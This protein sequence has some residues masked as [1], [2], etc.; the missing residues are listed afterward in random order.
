MTAIVKTRSAAHRAATVAM[1][2]LAV[3]LLAGPRRAAADCVNEA[4]AYGIEAHAPQ[5]ADLTRLLDEVR[6]CGIGWIRIDVVWS[7]VEPSQNTFNWSIYDAIASAAQARGIAVYASISNTPAWATAGPA[8]TGVPNNA[9]DFYDIC[10]RAA[11]RYPNT[12]RH[13]GMWNEPNLSQFWSGTRQQYI[14]IILKNGADAIHAGN[15]NAKVC[16]PELAHLSS[17]AWNTWLQDCITQAGSRLDI[18]T[19]H[20][21]DGD[22]NADVTDKLEDPPFWPWD[23]PS[24]KQVLQN[25]GWLGKPFWLTETGWESNKVGEANQAT[26]YAGLLT[27]WFTGLSGRDWV[28]KVFFYELNDTQAFSQ[29]SFGILGPDPTYPRKQAFT[30]CQN[31]IAAHPPA[32]LK[33]TGPSPAHLATGIGTNADLGWTAGCGAASHNVYFGTTSPGTYRGNQTATTYDPGTLAANTTYYWR[34]DAV[35]AGGTTT[36]DVWQFTTGGGAYTY[37]TQ[38]EFDAAPDTAAGVLDANPSDANGNG[39][40]IKVGTGYGNT[41]GGIA[42]GVLRFVDSSSS[43]D[44]GWYWQN[45]GTAISFTADM[46]VKANGGVSG[47]TAR[48]SMAFSGGSNMNRGL[49]LSQPNEGSS[50]PCTQGSVHFNGDDGGKGTEA[51][52]DLTGFR[53]LRVTVN[54]ST[55][56]FRVYDLDAQAELTSTSGGGSGSAAQVNNKGGFHIGSIAGAG[57]TLTDY[58]VDYVR[59]LL[60]TALENATTAINP[61]PCDSPAIIAPPESQTTCPGETAT[62]SVTATGTGPLSYQWTK[63][64]GVIAGATSSSYTIQPVGAGDAGS[65]ACLVSNPCASRESAAATLTVQPLSTYYRDADGDTYGDAGAAVQACGVSPPA[66]YVADG[67]D[68][69]D[70][71]AAVHPGAT[72]VCGNHI[73]DNCD[74]QTDEGCYAPADFDRDGDVDLSDFGVFQSCF[75]GPNRPAAPDCTADADLDDDNDVDL[76]DF[77]AFQSCFNGPN[78]FAAPGCAD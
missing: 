41:G 77:G 14:D 36:G 16:G 65:Y 6:A 34:I 20:V 58:E 13:W 54:A 24:V 42:N 32:P 67:T 48:R 2:S 61:I 51:C 70:T 76:A 25:A 60:G 26:Y 74:G 9:A 31:F 46:R 53:R 22:G 12:I 19:H 8:G 29:Y 55:N 17:G 68:C 64:G 50:V 4:S 62:F 69:D 73:D 21:Y 3:F 66:G 39:V 35:N 43:G 75:N 7:W 30:A 72:E 11:A 18:V 59:V 10:Y 47:S 37:S 45:G 57:T 38:Y 33:A 56:T 23:P 78:R 1:A 71:S 27:D 49:R 40:L 52:V 5:G 63:N 15:P 44:H 28:H